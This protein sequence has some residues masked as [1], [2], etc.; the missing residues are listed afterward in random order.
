MSIF[1]KTIDFIFP[2][3]PCDMRE[4]NNLTIKQE[5]F[6]GNSQNLPKL[7]QAAYQ[8]YEEEKERAKTIEGKASMFITSS[9]FLGTVL[10][11]TSNILV[12]QREGPV[13]Y[14]LLMIVCLLFFAVYMVAT[15]IYSIRAL[16]RAAYNRPDPTTMLDFKNPEDYDKQTISDLLNSTIRNQNVAN[17]KMDNVEMA[18]RF[19]QHLMFTVLLFVI[20]LLLYILQ[21]NG[22]SLMCWLH[23][24]N[25]EVQTW[26]IQLWYIIISSICLLLSICLGIIALTK[27]SRHSTDSVLHSK[28]NSH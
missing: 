6:T 17:R 11:G 1:R 4:D 9:A 26:S 18:Q 16:K 19:F 22:I 21:Q 5:T 2:L 27:V 10:I 20:I 3:M 14:K 13:W 24:I 7:A 8:Y 12:G 15:I 23:S 28:T 25:E